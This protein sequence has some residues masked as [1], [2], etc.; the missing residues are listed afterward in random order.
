MSVLP[1]AVLQ[2][3]GL[4]AFVFFVGFWAA[5]DRIEP[6]LLAAAGTLYGAGLLQ[7]ASSRLKDQEPPPA[8]APPTEPG[9]EP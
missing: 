2:V 4:S 7:H 1:P 5:T 6:T 8:P 3:V 9:S